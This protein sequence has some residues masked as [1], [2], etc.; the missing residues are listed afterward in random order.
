MKLTV[1]GMTCGH[2]VRTITAALQQLDPSARVDVDLAD[3][4]VRVAGDIDAEAATRAIEDAGYS[5]VSIAEA[6]IADDA[7]PAARNCCGSCHA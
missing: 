3:A 7:P 2:C 6:A 1:E 5:V 4:E